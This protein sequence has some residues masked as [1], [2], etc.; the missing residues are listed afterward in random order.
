VHSGDAY[1]L[2][3]MPL[4]RRLARYIVGRTDVVIASSKSTRDVLD[5]AL[6]RPSGAL[7]IPMGV[8]FELFGRAAGSTAA[9]SPFRGGY[10]LFVGRLH[11]IKGVHYLLR[12][13]VELRRRHPDLGLV[14]IG[15]GP[16]EE[17]LRREVARLELERSVTFAG[18]Q[19]HRVVASYVRGC[20]ARVVPSISEESGRTEGVP[21]VVLEGLAA[22]AR[23]VCSA[24]GGV[25]EIVRHED[26]GWLCREKD[27][28]DLTDKILL[29]LDSAAADQ[30][31]SRAVESARAFAWPR[32]AGRCSEIFDEL[33][34]P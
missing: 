24:V 12:S 22:G 25:P 5:A 2:R 30:L 17:Q 8:D 9:E 27:V 10:L 13:M 6:G 26:N 4:G 33:A 3:Q 29:A 23:M 16:F 28:A 19:P 20:R 21:T 11:E 14:V 7:V 1:R 18:A 32:I 34:R 15:Y 31:P